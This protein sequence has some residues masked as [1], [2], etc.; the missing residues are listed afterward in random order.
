MHCLAHQI[1]KPAEAVGSKSEG[2]RAQKLNRAM[3]V[4]SKRDLIRK[5][6]VKPKPS[7]RTPSLNVTWSIDEDISGLQREEFVARE[8]LRKKELVVRAIATT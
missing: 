2:Q 7:T 6:A 4:P 1:K 8:L 3:M 5:Q